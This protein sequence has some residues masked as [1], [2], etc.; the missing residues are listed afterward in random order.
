[1]RLVGKNGIVVL[2]YSVARLR[3]YIILVWVIRRI[4]IGA[5]QFGAVLT[6][7]RSPREQPFC[8]K[9]VS[10][11]SPSQHSLSQPFSNNLIADLSAHERRRCQMRGTLWYVLLHLLSR[12]S[13]FNMMTINFLCFNYLNRNVEEND[14]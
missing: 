7:V 10:P 11:R 13:L 1:M 5:A 2:K 6:D 14:T 9:F 8:V 4:Q 12:S 3:V